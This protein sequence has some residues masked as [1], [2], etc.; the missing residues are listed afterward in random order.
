MSYA[1]NR[2]NYGREVADAIFREFERAVC[3]RSYIERREHD[4][5]V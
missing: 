4:R 3:N 1:Q 2:A 5:L